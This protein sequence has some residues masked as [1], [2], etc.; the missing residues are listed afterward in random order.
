MEKGWLKL[1]R[2]ALSNNEIV[3]VAV[4]GKM[5]ETDERILTFV[6]RQTSEY[7]P[8][9]WHVID[10]RSRVSITIELTETAAITSVRAMLKEWTDENIETC[11]TDA[12]NKWPRKGANYGEST[13]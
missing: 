10:L 9:L 13:V 3:E 1:H 5:V 4:E 11:I 12:M 2:L 8:D 7:L 6:Y